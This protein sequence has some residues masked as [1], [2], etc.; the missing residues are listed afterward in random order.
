MLNNNRMKPGLKIYNFGTGK[1]QSV[2]EA[3]KEFQKQTGVSIPYKFTNKREGDISISYCS[4]KKAFKELNWKAK[5]DLKKAMQD[6][7]KT[8]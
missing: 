7:K 4:P 8:L 6:I 5:Y 3:L 1:G 2:L